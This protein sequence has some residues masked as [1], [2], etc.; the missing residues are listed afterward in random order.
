[1]KI[2]CLRYYLSLELTKY[3]LK[4]YSI[5]VKQ[6]M[7]ANGL[8]GIYSKNE[9]LRPTVNITAV[10]YIGESSFSLFLFPVQTVLCVPNNGFQFRC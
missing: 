10:Y 5:H 2:F 6:I 4:I 8:M 3:L 1:M 7:I 9:T